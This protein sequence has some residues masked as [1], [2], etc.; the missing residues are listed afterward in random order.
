MRKLLVALLLILIIPAAVVWVS[1]KPAPTANPAGSFSFGVLGDAPYYL[2]EEW[3]YDNVLDALDAHDL[4]AVIHV[5]DIFWRP[6]SDAMYRRTLEQFNAL[7]HPVIYTPGDNEWT[8][9]WEAGSGAFAPLER[10]GR[11]R[12][13]FFSDPHRSLGKKRIALVRQLPEFVENARWKM[14]GV[15]F[16]TVHLAGSR[17]AMR[18]FPNRTASDDAESRRRTLAAT[19]WLRGAF[20]DARDA[21]AMVVAFHA[22]PDFGGTNADY[23]QAYE[24]FVSA[25]E[26]EAARFARPVLVVQGDAHDYIVDRPLRARNVTRMQVPGSP[27][28]GWVRVIVRSDTRFAFEK[29]VVPRWKYW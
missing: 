10:L 20:Q 24:P 8:D 17:N 3:Q 11:L 23:R 27:E 28:V 1:R 18:P 13:I 7:R 2:W 21:R 5:G 6:C 19:D 12:E 22:N 14:H 16:V 15:A 9:C 4:S 29:H 26:E 25:L